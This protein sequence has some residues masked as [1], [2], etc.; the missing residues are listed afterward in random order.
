LYN[1]GVAHGCPGIISFLGQ[2][3]AA[4]ISEHESRELLEGSVR[5]LLARRVSEDSDEFPASIVIRQDDLPSKPVSWCYG[6]PGIAAALL[7]AARAVG[8]ESWEHEARD[9]ALKCAG[10]RDPESRVLE[11]CLCHGSAGNGH[12][13]NRL[14]QA[15]GEPRLRDAAV[16]WFAHALELR[17]PGTGLAGFVSKEYLEGKLFWQGQPGF[18]NGISGI[19]LALLAATTD[20]TPSWD[21]LLLA[22]LPP[23]R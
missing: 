16:F 15:T 8:E 14:Y 11:A 21:R 10:K 19:G 23:H 1:L 18:L 6:N 2:V 3:C 12:L 9:M 20:V 22:D 4:G 5:W 13:F 17:R 7:V